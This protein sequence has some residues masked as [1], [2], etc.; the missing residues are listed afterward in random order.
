MSKSANKLSSYAIS[1]EPAKVPIPNGLSGDCWLHK[2]PGAAWKTMHRHPELELNLVVRGAATYLLPDRRY[3]VRRGSLLWLFPGQNHLLLAQSDDLEMWVAVFHQGIILQ[4]CGGDQSHL[5]LSALPTGYFLKQLSEAALQRLIGHIVHLEG[6]KDNHLLFNS[7]IGYLLLLAWEGFNETGAE[8]C[9]ANLHHAVEAAMRDITAEIEA[10]SVAQIAERANVS[11][12]R[13]SHLFKE[14]TGVS[15]SEFRNLKRMERF[16][17]SYDSN[18]RMT[19]THAAFEA[20]FGSYV[21][22]HRVFKQLIGFSPRELA[23]DLNN[24]AATVRISDL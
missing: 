16:M 4:T 21:Q 9:P 2:G 6:D 11:V 7:G 1:P 13:L 5:L 18:K 24:H 10:L 17:R 14:Q 19:L 20:G 22:F 23:G 8:P 3:D 12:S 15:I